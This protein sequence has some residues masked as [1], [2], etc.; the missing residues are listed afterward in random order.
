MILP[1]YSVMM[2]REFSFR[3]NLTVPDD[4]DPASTTEVS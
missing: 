1:H 3:I 2:K 4:P